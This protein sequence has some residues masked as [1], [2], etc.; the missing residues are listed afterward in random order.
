MELKAG[1]KVAVGV[2]ADFKGM[3]LEQYDQVIE[4]MGF[5]PE[6]RASREPCST[7]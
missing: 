4:Q 6:V 3:T 5:S 2:Q 7:G 1:S